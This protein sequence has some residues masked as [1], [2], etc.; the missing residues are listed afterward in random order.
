MPLQFKK[1]FSH[2]PIKNMFNAPITENAQQTG[3]RSIKKVAVLG[4]GVMGSRIACHFA[5]I[6]VKVL[7]LDIVPKDSTLP[8]NK[9]VNDDLAA[10]IKGKPAPLYIEE[11]KRLIETGNFEDDLAKVADC[12]WIL[13]AIIERLDIKQMMYEKL[14]KVRKPGAIITSNTSGI[15]IKMLCEGRSEDFRRNFVG[16]HF[17]NP[18]RYLRLLEIIPGPDTTQELVDFMMEYGDL[19]LGKQMVLCKDTPAFIA[20]RVG[21][22]AMARVTELAIEMDMTIEEVD[23]LTG[24]PM[25]RPNTGTFRL[26]D[27]VGLDTAIKVQNGIGQNCPNDE[28]RPLFLT[29]PPFVEKMV[30]NG[31]I[32]DKTGQGYYKKTKNEKGETEILSL[33]LH[34]CEYVA[35][36]P[37][38]FASLDAAKQMENLK[39]RLGFFFYEGKDKGAE[40]VKRSLTGLF[41]Y[42]S[43]R[44]PE[45][46]DEL[47]RIDDGLR[48]GF[49]WD[50][51]PFEVWDM[52][53]VAKSI[54]IV[55]NDGFV[56]GDWVKEMVAAG[57]KSFYIVENGVRKYYDPATKT[58]KSI[59]GTEDL[60]I[61]ENLKGTKELWNNG[62]SAIIDIGDGVLAFEFRSKA[63]ALGEAVVRGLNYAI[64]FAEKNNYLGL[65]VGNEAPN[66]SF[67]ANLALVQM[68][69]YNDE[70]DELHFAIKAF[71]DTAMR[72]R[73]ASIPVIFAPQGMTL[74]GGCEYTMHS[75]KAVLAAETY[76]GLVEVGVGLIPGGGGTK[77]FTLRAA[78][79]YSKP[80]VVELP[81]LQDYFMAIATAKVAT[82][83]EE[84]RKMNILRESD[85][86]VVNL[87]RRLKVAKEAV[88][89]LAAK[90]YTPVV[91][92]TDIKVLGKSALS[93]LYAG[94]FGMYNAQYASEHDMKIAKKVAYIMCG[95]DLSGVN[96]VSEQ[97][98]LDLEREAFLSLL[99]EKKT[100][101]RIA[102]TL[103]TG[104]PLRN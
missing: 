33:D 54:E 66:F 9:I 85:L 89:D 100:M 77:E 98:L 93:S 68:M 11:S 96:Y 45:I 37:V 26:G 32:G 74:G 60:I 30:A 24:S 7:L 76:I 10:A 17:F 99:G 102:H 94:V 31:W 50:K 79:K 20:N 14:E 103:K 46:S 88:L 18:P 19:F 63:N 73:T 48:T 75:A 1:S 64:E 67:G 82:S 65:V 56:V 69:V 92:K 61:L 47:Y 28:Q 70:W 95:G 87:N 58:Y 101:E 91:P 23:K 25:G 59:P 41:A 40:F 34:T 44:I 15:P 27:L 35:K 90:G 97:Y 29:T 6:G 36:R 80:G 51:G 53:G 2:L 52:V 22:Y 13:E 4:S 55:E 49:A 83:G 81:I 39:D 5:N 62:D 42:I 8:R 78:E 38:K 12:D 104:K 72:I 86:V 84:A 57:N 71:Q 3:T 21:I 43:H 16:T